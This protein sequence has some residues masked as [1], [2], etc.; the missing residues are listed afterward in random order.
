MLNVA[1]MLFCSC[2]TLADGS[3]HRLCHC[4]IWDDKP[5][6]PPSPMQVPHRHRTQICLTW[7][8]AERRDE[9]Q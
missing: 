9:K 4:C 5:G 8:I 3:V 2:R 7:L 1:K 6:R